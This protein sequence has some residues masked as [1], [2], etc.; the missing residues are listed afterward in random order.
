MKGSFEKKNMKTIYIVDDNSAMQQFLLFRIPSTYQVKNFE[1][2]LSAYKALRSE[3][4]N[5]ELLIIDLS[6]PNVSGFELIQ[7]IKRSNFLSDIPIMVLSGTQNSND[8]IEALALGV[9]YF[10]SKPFHPREFDLILSRFLNKEVK[11]NA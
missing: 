8:R 10:L 11:L 2:G 6:L 7:M 3:Q 5:P 1:D 4:T 9:D